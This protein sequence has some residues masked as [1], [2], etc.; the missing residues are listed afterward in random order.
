MGTNQEQDPPVVLEPQKEAA[1]PSSANTYRLSIIAAGVLAFVVTG[2]LLGQS[3]DNDPQPVTAS[4]PSQQNNSTANAKIQQ[5]AHTGDYVST[6]MKAA[7]DSGFLKY[8]GKILPLNLTDE[9]IKKEFIASPYMSPEVKEKVLIAADKGEKK[10]GM[11][12]LWDNMDEDGDAVRIQTSEGAIDVPLLHTPVK[13]FIPYKPGESLN[14][15]GVHDGSGG[16]TA[17]I[18]TKSGTVPLPL[19]SVGQIIALPLL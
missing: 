9:N 6:D 18:E 16:I 14:I 19:M 13:V 10:I 3:I 8:T 2:F 7:I 15:I 17:A 1:A 12:M 11:V 5:P 4:I